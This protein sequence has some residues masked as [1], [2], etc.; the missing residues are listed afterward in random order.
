M[1][2]IAGIVNL[3]PTNA[4]PPRDALTRMANALY[5]RGPDEFGIYRDEHAGLAHARLSIIDLTTGQQP[6]ANESETLW[7]VFNGEIFNYIELRDELQKRGHRFRT[8]SDTEVVVHAFEEWAEHA[9][10][11]MNG[12][13]ALALWDS[14]R[15]KLV[16]SRDRLG[17]RPLYFAEHKGKLYFA[18]EVK[19]MFA[20]DPSLPRELDPVGIGQTFTFWSVVPP[21]TVFRGIEELRP[22]HLRVYENGQ[23]EE[24]AYWLPQYPERPALTGEFRGSVEEATLAVLD[25]L[26]KAVSLRVLRADVPVGTYL[27]GGLDSSLVAALGRKY[28]T[29][30]YQTFSV[31]FEDAEYDE[32]RFQGLMLRQLGSEHHEIMIRRAD[33]ASVFPEVVYHTERPILRTAP[34]P[35]FLLSRLVR[36]HGAEVVLTGEGADEMFAGYDLFRE[37]KIRRF[38]ARDPQSTLRPRALE[39]LYP[40]LTR[41]PVA[42]QAMARQFF[43]WNLAGHASPGFA[44]E[45]RWRTTSALMRLLHPDFRHSIAPSR[46]VDGFLATLPKEFLSWAPLAQDQYIELRTLLSGYLLSSQGDRMLMAHSVE[47][48]FPFLDKDVIELAN[49]LPPAY[50]LRVLDEK[51][52]VKRAAK[53]LIPDEIVSRQK[54]P[55]RAPDARSFTGADAP[56]Y[57]QEVLDPRN[58][59]D[60]GIFEPK[61]IAQLWKKCSSRGEDSEFS[62]VDNMALVGAVSTQLLHHQFVRARPSGDRPIHWCKDVERIR[63]TQ[64]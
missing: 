57:V 56:E 18:S 47:G 42:R 25:A 53:G 55:Y 43:G 10:E 49:S 30:R 62:N 63:A 24:R 5:H 33:I 51:H 34:A 7:V 15:R 44:H 50:K 13:W 29:G 23:V 61:A 12:Q 26:D 21:Q 37:G 45:T 64:R 3:W 11:R 41:S 46:I 2:G 28:A 52:V 58:V 36:Q 4:V 40:Y 31:R 38:W 8:A 59:A 16:L 22:G 17:V 35:L 14:A 60:A 6:L 39:R 20:A 27:S 9:F 32:S 54:Q 19:A 1:C 48:R